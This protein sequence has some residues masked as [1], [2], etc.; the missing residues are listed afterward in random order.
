MLDGQGCQAAGAAG[1]FGLFLAGRT[2]EALAQGGVVGAVAAASGMVADGAEGASAAGW[3]AGMEGGR[4]RPER[5]TPA[6]SSWGGTGPGTR[7]ESGGGTREAD[8]DGQ[9][10]PNYGCWHLDP[11]PP[12]GGGWGWQAPRDS[13]KE[14]R[15]CAAVAAEAA[16]SVVRGVG[17][18]A[19]VSRGKGGRGTQ[20]S[21]STLWVK[22]QERGAGPTGGRLAL[23][24]WRSRSWQGRRRG[25]GDSAGERW[26]LARRTRSPGRAGGA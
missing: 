14:R 26:R 2:S 1:R 3:T 8:Q 5:P 15:G 7:R 23:R 11:P 10:V 16:G 9:G 4:G 19:D 20:E 17:A 25:A 24:R 12:R 21:P 6:G 13:W 22:G 18:M